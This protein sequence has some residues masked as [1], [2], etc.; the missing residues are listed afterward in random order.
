MGITP[1]KNSKLIIVLC[2][3]FSIKRPW[4]H[5]EAGAGWGRGVKVIPM[6]HS[7][8][9]QEDLSG[10]LAVYQGGDLQT[11][12]AVEHLFK[13]IAEACDIKK[14][15]V[16]SDAFV[17]SIQQKQIFVENEE[18]LV[19]IDNL[20]RP[21]IEDFEDSIYGSVNT[22]LSKQLQKG[23]DFPKDF[24]VSIDDFWEAISEK[25]Y[26]FFVHQRGFER[27]YKTCDR[28]LDTIEFIVSDAHIQIS[29]ST[30]LFLIEPLWR[31]RFSSS[32]WYDFFDSQSIDFWQKNK[33]RVA[34]LKEKGLYSTEMNEKELAQNE[35]ILIENFKAFKNEMFESQVSISNQLEESSRNTIRSY[36]SLLSYNLTWI[37]N[38]RN[39]INKTIKIPA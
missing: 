5:F 34:D 20:L 35:E 6:R 9:K 36:F 18:V 32:D 30:R 23:G 1:I 27:F 33:E 15:P 13:T 28:L 16:V 7:G 39:L 19:E 3:P 29:S 24:V 12:I 26:S 25:S 2:S 17:E 4:I 31:N 37:R 14:T 11:K 8:L 10:N 21:L 22:N 38:Y